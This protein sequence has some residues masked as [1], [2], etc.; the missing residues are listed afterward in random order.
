MTRLGCNRPVATVMALGV[1]PQES[2]RPGRRR[3]APSDVAWAVRGDSGGQWRSAGSLQEVDERLVH[4][5][6]A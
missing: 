5:P 1:E 3:R 2:W 4:D 6:A